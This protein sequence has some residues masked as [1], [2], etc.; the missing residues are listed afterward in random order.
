MK[1]KLTL[2][3]DEDA[4]ARAKEYAKERGTSVSKLVENFFAALESEQQEDIEL[5]PLVQE[6]AG[7][8]A[9]SDLS[10]EDYYDYLEEKYK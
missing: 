2:R 5:S 6:L 7:I 4:I 3:M 8:A 10:E 9:G 1:K